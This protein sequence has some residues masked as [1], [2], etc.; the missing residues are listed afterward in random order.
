MIDYILTSHNLFCDY[1][2]GK[3]YKDLAERPYTYTVYCT[4]IPKMRNKIREFKMKAFEVDPLLV[5]IRCSVDTDKK[6][7]DHEEENL[8]PRPCYDLQR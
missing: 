8:K 1:N 4:Y 5:F 2:V 6:Y 7:K 3:T